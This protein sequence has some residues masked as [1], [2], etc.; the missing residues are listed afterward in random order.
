[1]AELI[2][3]LREI[4]GYLAQIAPLSL[5]EEGASF[6][7]WKVHARGWLREPDFILGWKLLSTV[8]KRYWLKHTHPPVDETPTSNPNP[9]GGK[10]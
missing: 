9:A 6:R 8:E 7:N 3:V 2:S 10:T 5:E 1:M 4:A